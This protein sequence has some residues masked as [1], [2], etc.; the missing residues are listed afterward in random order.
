MAVVGVLMGIGAAYLVGFSRGLQIES[1]ASRVAAF[2]NI[3]RN[4]AVDTGCSAKLRF[5]KRG[6]A[7][8]M[9]Y[10]GRDITDCYMME[11]TSGSFGR[12]FTTSG[13]FVPGL[14]GQCLQLEDG[15]DADFGENS[16]WGFEQGFHIDLFCNVVS[17]SGEVEFVKKENQFTLSL[18]PSGGPLVYLK[19]S[20]VLDDSTEKVISNSSIVFEMNR[21]V[22]IGFSCA[23]NVVSLYLDGNPV[24]ESA[25]LAGEVFSDETGGGMRLLSG[26]TGCEAF[27]DE[28]VI[29]RWG[30]LGEKSLGSRVCIDALEARLSDSNPDNDFLDITFSPDGMYP[31]T[32]TLNVYFENDTF[33][34]V[35]VV[36]GRTGNIY[37]GEL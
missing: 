2:L 33:R 17:L 34:S 9:V 27:V 6:S 18:V 11:N 14:A 4:T 25:L 36:I 8:V 19:G 24:A 20:V 16:R 28:M 31:G 7:T 22:N 32:E 1:E 15:E 21:W 30:I 37:K 23:G 26:A 35:P 13:E 29:S 3:T 5:V 10:T 12:T